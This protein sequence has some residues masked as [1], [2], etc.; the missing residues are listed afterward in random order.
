VPNIAFLNGRFL[1]LSKATVHVEDRGYQFGDGVYELI[2]TYHGQVFFLDDHLSRM[3]KSA[4]AIGLG[5]HYSRPRWKKIIATAHRKSRF[6]DARIYIQVTRGVAPR[7]HDIPKKIRP[8]VVVT[9]RRFVPVSDQL[10][11]QGVSIMTLE[12]FRWGRCDLKSINLL[13]NI[14]AKHK[15]KA[16]GYFEAVFIRNGWVTEGSTSNIFAVF[17]GSLITPPTG[18][19]LLAGITRDLVLNLAR[20]NGMDVK[21]RDISLDEMY[22]AD[23]LF[24]T[25]TSV[26]ILP[27]VK[28][29]RY[30]IGT[31]RPG[32]H[33]KRLYS[34]FESLTQKK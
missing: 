26:E 30:S 14:L 6:P 8:T 20:R 24:L 21:E 18:S 34:L 1:P 4:K 12:D 32:V 11:E 15:A 22:E 27:V 10:R 9:V 3:E 17:G 31:G 5:L 19:Y 25:G 23:E 2:R 7:S 16:E 29:N 13:P 33:T 28:V